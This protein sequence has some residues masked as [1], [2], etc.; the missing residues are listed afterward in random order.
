MERRIRVSWGDDVSPQTDGERRVAERIEFVF[1]TWDPFAWSDE[2]E[3]DRVLLIEPGPDGRLAMLF[4]G[5]AV[6]RFVDPLPGRDVAAYAEWV[7]R[8]VARKMAAFDGGDMEALFDEVAVEARSIP[9]EHQPEWPS[10]AVVADSGWLPLT[11]D[12]VTDYVV[13]MTGFE[14]F[15]PP[16]IRLEP[17]DAPVEAC[18]SCRGLRLRL[19]FE[20]DEAR[21]DMCSPHRAAA[22]AHMARVVVPKEEEDEWALWMFSEVV[23]RRLGQRHLPAPVSARL[24][25][26]LFDDPS[27]PER[28]ATL[29]AIVDGLSGLGELEEVLE[30]A[31]WEERYG[32][33]PLSSFEAEVETVAFRLG[34]EGEFE[35]AERFVDRMAELHPDRAASLHAELASSAAEAGR[36]DVAR[37]RIAAALDAPSQQLWTNL[38]L[39]TAEAELG[40]IDAA[41]ER[42]G[43]ARTEARE[44]GDEFIERDALM[45]L[46]DLLRGLADP[47]RAEDLETAERDLE[48][49]SDRL[50]PG[51]QDPD[52]LDPEP[53]VREVLPNEFGRKVGRNEPC[54]CGSGQKYKKCHGR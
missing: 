47:E 48:V 43:Q 39:A 19:P 38:I 24:D 14:P 15:D 6:A 33:E 10:P 50:L 2:V 34:L 28:A 51:R 11:I 7:V 37:R 31:G 53:A 16:T 22:N 52:R 23:G 4:A 32:D 9:S 13:A 54:P 25:R 3:L 35:L 27:T 41:V 8:S 5:S 1:L 46:C 40:D 49:L 21:M 17:T 12:T 30:D 26:M 45:Q 42:L 18:P 29:L 44:A 36:E 20:L